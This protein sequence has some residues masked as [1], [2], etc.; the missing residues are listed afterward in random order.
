VPGRTWLDN[1][2]DVFL[3]KLAASSMHLDQERASELI[4]EQAR[5]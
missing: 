1:K 3:A 2:I 5:A 4:T